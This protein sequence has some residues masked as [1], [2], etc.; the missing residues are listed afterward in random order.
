MTQINKYMTRDEYKT[1]ARLQKKFIGCLE[2]CA[3]EISLL[4]YKREPYG[5]FCEDYDLYD[6]GGYLA[7]FETHSCGDYDTDQVYV[8][9]AYLND[10]LYRQN[11]GAYLDKQRRDETDT[12]ELEKQRNEYVDNLRKEIHERAEYGRLRKKFEDG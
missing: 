4:K 7:Q 2:H 8:P 11:Y 3:I 9:V 1:Y 6:K 12:R 10:D 5:E